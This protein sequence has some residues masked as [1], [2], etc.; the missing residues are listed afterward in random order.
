[1]TP[2]VFFGS[3]DELTGTDRS[4]R[5]GLITEMRTGLLVSD[6]SVGVQIPVLLTILFSACG[7]KKSNH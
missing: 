4:L 7:F 6:T 1:M 2:K 3:A 5:S